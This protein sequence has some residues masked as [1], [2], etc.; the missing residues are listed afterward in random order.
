MFLREIHTP[1]FPDDGFPWQ[2]WSINATFLHKE[3]LLRNPL[4]APGTLKEPVTCHTRD[5]PLLGCIVLGSNRSRAKQMCVGTEVL[6]YLINL[7][8]L[9]LVPASD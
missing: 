6:I 1:Q 7:A 3:V 5:A 9:L 8:E 4:A 2:L